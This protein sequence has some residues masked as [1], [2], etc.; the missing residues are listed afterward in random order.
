MTMDITLCAV[1]GGQFSTKRVHIEGRQYHPLCAVA[2][3]PPHTPADAAMLNA[4]IQR[5]Q[6]I[7]DSRPA[8][9]A[10]LPGTYE[11]WSRSIYE[12]EAARALG[13]NAS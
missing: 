13:I 4:E 2:S 12:M 10:G 6:R 11:R 1:C 9:N 5:L 3:Y 7:I 8:I